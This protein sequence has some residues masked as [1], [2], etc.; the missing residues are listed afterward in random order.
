MRA[1]AGQQERIT[2]LEAEVAQALAS[3]AAAHEQLAL[4]ASRSG[5]LEKAYAAA[6]E[7]SS[8][9]VGLARCTW[10]EFE[11]PHAGAAHPT[12]GTPLLRLTGRHTAL[13]L[14]ALA[15][16]CPLQES[17]ALQTKQRAL[18]A[19]LASSQKEARVAA[20][21]QERLSG[22]AAELE[23]SQKEA[24][25]ASEQLTFAH[26]RTAVL[27][28]AYAAAVEVS[29]GSSMC[30]AVWTGAAVVCWR[31]VLGWQEQAAYP[32]Y[33]C[34]SRP[35]QAIQLPTATCPPLIVPP[36]RRRTACRPSS[37]SCR[38]RW[39]KRRRRLGRRWASQTGSPPCR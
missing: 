30:G 12:F 32:T 26:S 9:W 1:A 10:A 22:L 4:A 19:A 25:A 20:G 28:K 8:G 5:V 36:R 2:A 13:T 16:L 33:V 17:Q 14:A 7:V 27:E 15:P 21:L 11:A 3:A 23:A 24:A 37:A 18:Q 29:V 6:V 38:R 31:G 34:A 35:V 39:P